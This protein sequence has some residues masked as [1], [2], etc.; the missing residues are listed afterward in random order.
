MG[1]FC[2][3]VN[4]LIPL[5]A[6]DWLAAQMKG[7]LSVDSLSVE[8]DTGGLREHYLYITEWCAQD[9]AGAYPRRGWQNHQ[10]IKRH[11]HVYKQN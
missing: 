4:I 8:M 10:Q 7:G 1:C 11:L 3:F 9:A 2:E 5:D 6:H